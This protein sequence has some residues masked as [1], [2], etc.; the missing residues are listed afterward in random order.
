MSPLV[1]PLVALAAIVWVALIFRIVLVA[2]RL[3]G[4]MVGLKLGIMTT[5]RDRSSPPPIVPMALK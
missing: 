1:G 5:R 4:A 3:T 2:A